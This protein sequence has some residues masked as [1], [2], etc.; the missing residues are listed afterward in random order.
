MFLIH[1]EDQ[2]Q[3]LKLCIWTTISHQCGITEH[4]WMHP[5]LCKVLKI[6]L[7]TSLF[8]AFAIEDIVRLVS[9]A[10]I[11]EFLLNADVAVPV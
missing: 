7:C 2:K 1:H 9:V 5:T 4:F 10:T 3:V 6:G 11:V 8:V